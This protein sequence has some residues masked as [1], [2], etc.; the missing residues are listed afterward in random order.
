MLH[1]F[2]TAYIFSERSLE[3]YEY[4]NSEIAKWAEHFLGQKTPFNQAIWHSGKVTENPNDILLGHLTWDSRAKAQREL[5]GKMKHN[6]VKDN[7]LSSDAPAHPNTYILTPWV[8]ECPEEWSRRMPFYDDQLMAAS[9]IFGLCGE[10]WIRKTLESTVDSIQTRVSHKLVHCNMGLAAQN[11]RQHKRRFNPVGERQILHMSNLASYK[12]FEITCQ[13]VEHLDTLFHVATGSIQAEPGLLEFGIDDR[14]YFFNYLGHVD[15]NDPEFQEWV[16][17]NCDFYIHTA[18]ADAQATT[19]LE[20]CARGLVPLITPESGFSS[21][22]AIY[23][24][25]DPK[26]NREIIQWALELPEEE[27]MKRSELLREQIVRE[28]NW[29]DIFNKIWNEIQADIEERN[30]I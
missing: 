14:A 13:S 16:V 2:W 7:A 12:G 20:N 24:T 5:L 23:L 1:F 22:H 19:I 21:P 29:E 30:K 27:L 17:E 8:P 4:S 26:E 6:W 15:N 18:Y 3:F 10:F 28:H 11:F 9:K 25:H